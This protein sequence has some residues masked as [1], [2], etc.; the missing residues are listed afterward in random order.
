M[1]KIIVKVLEAQS[2]VVHLSISIGCVL[3][4][5]VID[6]LITLDISLSIFYLF[7]IA[8]ATW[9]LGL[10]VGLLIS[11]LATVLW[12]QADVAA[13]GQTLVLLPYWNAAVRFGFFCIVSYLLSALKEAYRREQQLARVDSL[14]NIYNRRFFLEL[15]EKE[16]QRSHRYRYSLT[17]AYLDIDNFKL[18]NDR[19]GH[20]TGDKLLQKVAKTLVDTARAND[21]VARLGGDEFAFL[22]PQTDCH[23]ASAALK[24]IY[25]ELQSL[26]E[27][28]N[29]PIGYSIGA[30]A[31][32]NPPDSIDFLI[33][34][35]D[36][37]MYK[38]KENGK[39]QLDC[40]P[41]SEDSKL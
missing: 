22:L 32:T 12:F 2:K 3:L 9:F 35:V 10:R 24:R 15:L 1:K 37:L 39:N 38:V 16:I 8:A 31:F 5:G 25:D 26:S 34:Q 28:N 14:T 29:W 19:Y 21:I 6:W 23:Q 4:I 13:K 41:F 27:S 33:A 17:L 36:Q 11:L 20:S 30:M 7:P 40:Q 18:V